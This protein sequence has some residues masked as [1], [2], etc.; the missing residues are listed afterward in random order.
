MKVVKVRA[1][2]SSANM[3]PG[4]D[5]LALAHNAFYDEVVISINESGSGVVKIVDVKGPYGNYVPLEENTGKRA[6]E[7]ILEKYLENR[8]VDIKLKII[9]GI[10]VGLGLGSSGATAA[11]TVKAINEGLNLNL[12][13]N[14]LIEI[15]GLAEEVSAG[16]P[17]YDNVAA[18]LLGNLAIIYSF[19]PVKAVSYKVNASFIVAIPE[20]RMPEKKTML[21]RKV[22]PEFIELRKAVRNVGRTLILFSGLIEGDISRICEGLCDE[23]VEP[24]RE[25]LVPCYRDLKEKLASIGV[26][27]IVLSG[28]GPSVIIPYVNSD[29][30]E[31]IVE[32]ISSVYK[33][34]GIKALIKVVDPAPGAHVINYIT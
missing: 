31:K 22:I 9:K 8:K 20:I 2:S 10:P 3:G 27:N 21:L 11:A 5:V 18:S 14:R 16:S 15:A 7:I 24:Y 19:N 26:R 17:H 1:Y 25:P 29:M 33:S 32:K 6:A 23:A 30:Y 28:A 12:D 4:F 34:Y 13:D